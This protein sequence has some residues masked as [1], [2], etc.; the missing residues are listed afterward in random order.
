MTQSRLPPAG[1]R[2]VIKHLCRS[3]ACADP[4]RSCARGLRNRGA[5]GY[6]HNPLTWANAQVRGLLIMWRVMDSNQRRTTPTVLQGGPQ[7]GS[8][9]PQRGSRAPETANS[10]RTAI[11]A[12]CRSGTAGRPAWGLRRLRRRVAGRPQRAGRRPGRWVGRSPARRV[13][14]RPTRASA[15]TWSGRGRPR[16]P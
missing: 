15:G 9:Q 10:P 8:E 13:R 5:L 2:A 3:Q 6:P 4:Q 14:V 12:C 7:N 16:R 11:P 1:L